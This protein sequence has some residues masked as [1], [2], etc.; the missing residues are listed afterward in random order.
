KDIKKYINEIKNIY[1]IISPMKNDE[2]VDRFTDAIM[3]DEKNKRIIETISKI[4]SQIQKYILNED[5]NRFYCIDGERGKKY[6]IA[7]HI[8]R[9]IPEIFGKVED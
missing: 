9:T 5:I 7:N 8:K 6:G 1:S 3:T 4:N 2:V